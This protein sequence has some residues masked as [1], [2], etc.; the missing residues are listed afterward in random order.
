[1]ENCTTRDYTGFGYGALEYL[2]EKEFIEAGKQISTFTASLK[3]K[4]NKKEFR[5][6]CLKLIDYLMTIKDNPPKY[7]NR[8]RW[9]PVLR[10]YFGNKFDKLTKYGGCP[11]IFDQKDRDLLELKYNA[12]YFC[13]LNDTYLQKLKKFKKSGNTYDC[14]NDTQ[15][16]QDCKE[17]EKWFISKKQHF[18]E[19]RH[20][21]SE[22][23]IFKNT[24]SQFPEKKCNILDLKT[25]NELPQCLS[26]KPDVTSEAPA[27][28]NELSA[29][30]LD[31]REAEDENISQDQSLLQEEHPHDG[32]PNSPSESQSSSFPEDTPSGP[33]QLQTASEGNSET[34]LTNL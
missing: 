29:P 18:E 15:C 3:T 13:E 26:P 25:F 20:F 24:S 23:C 19:K 30:K 28:E 1:M 7:T 21:I 8:K 34:S 14:N 31:E 6:E 32:A 16:I 27:K 17:Y 22:S 11:M 2:M 10:N 33:P 5:D 12:L 4:K 9:V